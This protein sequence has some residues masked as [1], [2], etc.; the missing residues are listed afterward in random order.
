MIHR[1]IGGTILPP[2]GKGSRLS[3]YRKSPANMLYLSRPSV[4]C[5]PEKMANLDF[6]VVKPGQ[7]S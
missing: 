2:Q 1:Q 7:N 3:K 6:C 5:C 4:S